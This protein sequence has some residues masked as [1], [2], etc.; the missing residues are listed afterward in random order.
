VFPAPFVQRELSRRQGGA[1][2]HN[3]RRF[4]VRSLLL[5]VGQQVRTLIGSRWHL[6]AV[7]RLF[8]RTRWSI[9]VVNG[10]PPTV[11]M[12]SQQQSSQCPSF[13]SSSMAVARQPVRVASESVS[14]PKSSLTPAPSA[15]PVDAAHLSRPESRSPMDSPPGSEAGSAVSADFIHPVVPVSGVGSV[16]A[17]S[18]VGCTVPVRRTQPMP[19][20]TQSGRQFFVRYLMRRA[21]RAAES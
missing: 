12:Q 18:P 21:N 8:R 16:S 13:W 10:S 9:N 3:V 19:L 4:D 15:R 1:F 14:Q 20:F 7:G 2:F 11:S 5:F 6:G 17:V